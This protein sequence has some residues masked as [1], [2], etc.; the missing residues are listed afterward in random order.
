LAC[1]CW[2]IFPALMMGSFLPLKSSASSP[3][4]PEQPNVVFILG[5]NHH[6]GTMGCSGHP[7]IKTP[8]MDRLAR[9]GVIFENTFN[10]TAL[11]SPSRAS[12]LTGAYAHRHGVL[13][14]YTPWIGQMPTFLEYVS[15]GGYATALIGKWH[16]PGEGLPEMLFL[17]LF[18]SYTYREGQ[19]AYFNSNHKPPTRSVVVDCPMI[20][21]GSVSLMRI[22]LSCR[23]LYR[24]PGSYPIL[25]HNTGRWC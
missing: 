7:F 23:L 20:V 22:P 19:G 3:T 4:G 17:D 5:D 2:M 21:M 13:N 10:T 15:R 12:I 8:G 16:M 6:A 14:S 1:A 25:A 24:R 11:C 18:V 9:D